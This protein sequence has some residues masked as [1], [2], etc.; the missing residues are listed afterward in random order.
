MKPFLLCLDLKFVSACNLIHKSQR[1]LRLLLSL[2]DRLF[3][4][5]S[6]SAMQPLFHAPAA[7][8]EIF[9]RSL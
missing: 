9:A 5:Y 3:V 1:P 2:I 4:P 7:N 8:K 6:S